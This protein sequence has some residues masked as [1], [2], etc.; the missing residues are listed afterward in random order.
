[1][2]V[3]GGGGGGGG[4]TNALRERHYGES[5]ITIGLLHRPIMYM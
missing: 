5:L 3:G 2:C 4:G 1:M